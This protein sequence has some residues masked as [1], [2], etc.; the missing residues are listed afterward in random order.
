MSNC[1]KHAKLF[2]WS[3]EI[4][5]DLIFLGNKLPW[6]DARHV[7]SQTDELVSRNLFILTVVST[8]QKSSELLFTLTLRSYYRRTKTLFQKRNTQH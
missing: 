6:S 1:L 2:K 3:I 4:S 5:G 7:S 8:G